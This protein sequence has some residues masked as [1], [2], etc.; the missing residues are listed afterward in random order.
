VTRA[1]LALSSP[2]RAFTAI[3]TDRYLWIEY[4]T[5]GERKLYDLAR[6]PYELTSLH[7]DP[8]FASVRETLA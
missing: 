2:E 8:A 6:D 5:Q 1:S 7:T 4:T 3:R